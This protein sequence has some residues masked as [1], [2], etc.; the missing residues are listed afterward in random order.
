MKQYLFLY[1]MEAGNGPAPTQEETDANMQTW[2]EW[3]GLVADQNHLVSLGN[4][5][6]NSGRVVKPNQVV[7]NG[8]Y[9]EI[10]ESLGG[11]SVIQ[12]DSYEQ[13]VDIAKGCPIFHAGGNVEIREI[14]GM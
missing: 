10:K 1:R 14:A 4:R 5:L 3:L 7:T 11:Y 6:E 12:A 13:A 8:P 9:S 2:M